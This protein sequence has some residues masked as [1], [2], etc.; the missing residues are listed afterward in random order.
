MR[1]LSQAQLKAMIRMLK[2]ARI[3]IDA[4]ISYGICEALEPTEFPAEVGLRA[5]FVNWILEML[6]GRA[7]LNDWLVDRY[8]LTASIK[9]L[10]QIRLRWIDWMIGELQKEIK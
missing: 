3:K 10:K 1:K 2:R 7:W 5:Y 6:G 9:E 4:G 8:G